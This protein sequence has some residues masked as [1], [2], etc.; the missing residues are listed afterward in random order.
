MA[1]RCSMPAASVELTAMRLRPMASGTLTSKSP[2][3]PTPMSVSQRLAVL[4]TLTDA[5]GSE[6]PLTVTL[7]SIVSSPVLGAVMRR[8]GASRS[9]V[10]VTGS[11][12]GPRPP[13]PRSAAVSTFWPAAS[14]TSG[15]VTV[16]PTSGRS[17]LLTSVPSRRTTSESSRRGS[18]SS[19]TATATSTYHS[20]MIQPALGEVISGLCRGQAG[21]QGGGPRRWRGAR[22]RGSRPCRVSALTGAEDGQADGTQERGDDERHAGP[23]SA[24]DVIPVA[25]AGT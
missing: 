15:T 23:A 11:D 4:A 16:R 17:R 19:G 12:A 6:V 14:G 5:P 1:S 10:T 24:G 22:G 20:P 18:V 25:L 8:T 21:V 7:D 9:W 13:G 3:G 2:L